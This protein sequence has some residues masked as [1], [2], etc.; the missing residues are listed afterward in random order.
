MRVNKIGNI[1]NTVVINV[2]AFIQYAVPI[3]IFIALFETEG[4][5]VKLGV[6]VKIFI[7]AF[8]VIF[9]VW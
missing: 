8:V 9:A 3:G 2:F 1:Q 5:V 6:E 7:A 4:V